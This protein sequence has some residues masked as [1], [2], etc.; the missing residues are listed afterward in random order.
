[1]RITVAEGTTSTEEAASKNSFLR[2]FPNSRGGEIFMENDWLSA[3]I[4]DPKGV[5]VK[6]LT[7][8]P[9]PQ[10]LDVSIL[11]GGLYFLEILT[12]ERIR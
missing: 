3:H 1:M 9:L 10:N 4:M 7:V 2:I 12:K 6:R 5:E 8:S 11:P